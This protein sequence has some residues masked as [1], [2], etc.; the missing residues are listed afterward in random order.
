VQFGFFGIPGTEC[1]PNFVAELQS[2]LSTTTNELIFLD[3]SVR[4]TLEPTFA[5]PEGKPGHALMS[6][7]IAPRAPPW[8]PSPATFSP[9][10]PAQNHPDAFTPD[11]R[12]SA[13]LFNYRPLPAKI[14]CFVLTAFD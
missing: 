9:R 7:Y 3:D 12:S 6:I 10:T 11:F 13:P 5:F 8:K 4:G 2:K 14:S 1:N